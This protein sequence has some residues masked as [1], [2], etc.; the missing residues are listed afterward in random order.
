MAALEAEGEW[1]DE[2]EDMVAAGLAELAEAIAKDG[3][4]VAPWAPAAAALEVGLASRLAFLRCAKFDAAKAR[5][6]RARYWAY[7][8][9]LFPSTMCTTEGHLPGADHP[10]LANALRL[11]TT[12]F[13][14]GARDNLGRQVGWIRLAR[15]DYTIVEPMDVLRGLWFHMH[16]IH[17][18]QG[19]GAT[20]EAVGECHDGDRT[21][22]RGLFIVNNMAG[23]ARKN[24]RRE[25]L[26]LLAGSLQDLLPVRLG[27]VRILN[28]P[29]FFDWLWMLMKFFIR[30]K[31][32]ERIV[33]L[34]SDEAA[35][36][37][38]LDPASAIP[39][40]LGGQRVWDGLGWLASERAL[41]GPGGWRGAIAAAAAAAAAV[42][43][44]GLAG[45][46]TLLA[47]GEPSVSSPLPQREERI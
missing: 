6:R 36:T 23:L 29:V 14:I 31:L 33:V 4:D 10:C 34:G 41:A 21:Q 46:N 3:D 7:R 9:T 18:D 47:A 37:A 42:D 8:A 11:G 1:V 39:T 45:D 38:W 44:G 17:G 12:E 27:G 32:R 13:P 40:D 15:V 26:S 43:S 35:L 28:E 24:A 16:M 19:G 25:T 2:T 5:A 30:A 22:R 20:G